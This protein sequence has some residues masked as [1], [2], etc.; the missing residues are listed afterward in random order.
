M[1]NE[2]FLENE[3]DLMVERRIPHDNIHELIKY[4]EHPIYQGLK[5]DQVKI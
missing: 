2:D 1:S 5:D 4:G 3:E